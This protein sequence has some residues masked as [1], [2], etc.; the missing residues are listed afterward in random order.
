VLTD[1]NDDRAIGGRG[2]NRYRFTGHPVTGRRPASMRHIRRAASTI[3]DF[4]PGKGDRLVLS[5]RVFGANVLRL[6]HGFRIAVGRNP[7][8]RTRRAT[9]LFNPRTRVL[10]FDRD[11]IGPIPDQVIV[12][13][14]GSHRIPRRGWFRFVAR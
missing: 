6:R 7:R 9:L 12:R 1:E 5:A 13:L 10:R 14:R 8:P 11:G 4:Y 2:A 3:V